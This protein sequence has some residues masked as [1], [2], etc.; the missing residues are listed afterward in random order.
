ML[1]MTV[2]DWI[3]VDCPDEPSDQCKK[4]RGKPDFVLVHISTDEACMGNVCETGVLNSS[5]HVERFEGLGGMVSR[6]EYL[7]ERMV[8]MI[9][10]IKSLADEVAA[11]KSG[12]KPSEGCTAAT[13]VDVYTQTVH[14]S[15]V[16]ASFDMSKRISMDF[17][18]TGRHETAEIPLTKPPRSISHQRNPA[19]PYSCR[20][21]NDSGGFRCHIIQVH[22]SLYC[23]KHASMVPKSTS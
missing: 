5:E 9:S 19:T 1:I 16:V 14:T 21:S 18:H 2:D 3:E 22:E 12:K 10:K 15:E 17:V 7:E 20:H 6:I 13:S 23:T 4:S 11:F 8:D